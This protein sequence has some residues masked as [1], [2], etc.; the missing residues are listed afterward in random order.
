MKLPYE[1]NALEPVI[2]EKTMTFHY[3]KHHAAYV[4]NTNDMVKGTPLE[5]KALEEIILASSKD[6]K[7][8]GLYNNAAQ[9]W[10]HNLFWQCLTNEAPKKQ[11]PA[12]LMALITADFGSLDALKAEL[13]KVGTAQFGS[14]WVWLVLEKGHLKVYST[15]NGQNPLT[16]KDQKTLLGIDVWEHSYYLDYQNLRADFLQ[17]VLDSL[18]NWQYVAQNLK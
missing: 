12:D 5:N 17:K 4:K 15:P 14:G 11:V 6:A 7:L 10:N 2:S 18:I 3:T 8:A 13:K 1:L 16:N 9:T